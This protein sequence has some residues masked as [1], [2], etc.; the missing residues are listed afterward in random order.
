[1]KTTP[2]TPA[3][4]TVRSSPSSRMTIVA[5]PSTVPPNEKLSPLELTEL[6]EGLALLL[7]VTLTFV[8]ELELVVV[9][10]WFV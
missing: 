8:F 6:D 2:A 7:T 4:V 10:D 1:M 5:L 3:V 9:G